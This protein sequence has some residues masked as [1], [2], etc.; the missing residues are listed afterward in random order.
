MADFGRDSRLSKPSRL[1]KTNRSS[2]WSPMATAGRREP[3]VVEMMPKGMLAREK[4]E[5]GSMVSHDMVMVFWVMRDEGGLGAA[6][7]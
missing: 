5:A 4:G 3:F 1:A 2:A 6:C 7:E